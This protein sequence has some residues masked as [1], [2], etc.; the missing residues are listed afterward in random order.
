MWF[1]LC[2]YTSLPRYSLL[3]VQ[4][5]VLFYRKTKQRYMTV[6]FRNGR[7][8]TYNLQGLTVA[9]PMISPNQVFIPEQVVEILK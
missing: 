7:S 9:A 2:S 6:T 3:V 1:L 4:L 8:L 5:V